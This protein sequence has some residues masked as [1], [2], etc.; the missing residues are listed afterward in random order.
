MGDERRPGCGCIQGVGAFLM[1]GIALTV[2]VSLLGFGE[3]GAWIFVGGAI[4]IGVAFFLQP[5]DM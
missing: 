2:V 5:E 1:V 4:L 3:I